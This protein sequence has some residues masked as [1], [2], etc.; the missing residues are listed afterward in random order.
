MEE[1][2]FEK[3]PKFLNDCGDQDYDQLKYFYDLF[4]PYHIKI[5]QNNEK[6]KN[7]RIW[8]KEKFKKSL[9]YEIN[10]KGTDGDRYKLVKNPNTVRYD[11]WSNVFYFVR[12]KDA[13]IF[14]LRG[15]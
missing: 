12:K 5:E 7:A 6:L 8:C 14:R 2:I 9:Y 10:K 13:L 3:L 4:F 11:Y 15:T 1:N